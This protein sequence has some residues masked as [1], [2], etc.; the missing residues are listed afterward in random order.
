MPHYFLLCAFLAIFVHTMLVVAITLVY[1][2]H[3]L[4]YYYQLALAAHDQA[5]IV[6]LV[7]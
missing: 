2:P 5:R 1:R 7:Y 6:A 4:L 3:Y